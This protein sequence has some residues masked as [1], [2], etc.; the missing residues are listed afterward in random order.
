ADQVIGP[1]FFSAVRPFGCGGH[2]PGLLP[3]RCNASFESNIA[4]RV[5]AQSSEAHIGQLVLLRLH[6]EWKLCLVTQYVMV[7]FRNARARGTIPEM[8]VARHQTLRDERLHQAET[9]DH[10]QGRRM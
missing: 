1:K 2:R 9:I 7:E 4:F 5:L 3:K 8:E 10:L 6:D